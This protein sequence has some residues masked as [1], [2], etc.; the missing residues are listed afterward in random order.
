MRESRSLLARVYIIHAVLKDI[1]VELL[2]R[3]GIVPLLDVLLVFEFC[4]YGC[5]AS[6]VTFLGV[7]NGLAIATNIICDHPLLE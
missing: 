3:S 7:I 2:C 4:P 5:L 1:K 6:R